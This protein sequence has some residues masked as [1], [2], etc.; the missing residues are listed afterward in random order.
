MSRDDILKRISSNIKDFG[1]HVTIVSGGQEPRYAY[2]VG[3]TEKFDFELILAGSIY[4]F[5]DDIYSVVNFISSKLEKSKNLEE[6]SFIVD[7]LGTFKLIKVH[8]SWAEKTMLGVYDFY[9]LKTIKAYQ[10]V[11]DKNFMTIDIPDMSVEFN[12][13]IEPAWKWLEK[14][15]E[16][17]IPENITVVTNLDALKGEPITQ[18]MRWEEDEWEMF[19]GSNEDLD[20]D[21]VRVVPIGLLLSE[22]GTLLPALELKTGKGLWRESQDDE[23]NDWG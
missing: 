10:I 20:E 22:D 5:E 3:L 9:D 21:D 8:S 16:F 15:W 23:W 13:I 12:P 7:D 2:T 4:F 14:K 6:Q 19:A 11:P 18:V 1:H 17:K